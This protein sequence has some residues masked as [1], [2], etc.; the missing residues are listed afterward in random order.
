M[1]KKAVI[2]INY[3]EFNEFLYIKDILKNTSFEFITVLLK[4]HDL[5]FTIPENSYIINTENIF[6]EN[7][8]KE[9]L[10]I[11]KSYNPILIASSSS[12]NIKNIIGKLSVILKCGVLTDCTDI[13]IKG[14]KIIATKYA[15]GGNF[16]AKLLS[17]SDIIAITFKGNKKI[18]DEKNYFKP[19]KEIFVKEDE[20]I[21]LVNKTIIENYSSLENSKKVVGIGRGVK[22]EDIEMIKKF[23]SLI[24]ATVGYTRPVIYEYIGNSEL[25]IGITGK[26]I[27]PDLYIAIGISGKEYHIKGVEKAKKI[28][29]VNTDPQ[30]NIRKY[31]DYFIC[32]DY[33]DFLRKFLI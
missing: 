9:I 15:Y 10:E 32:A 16:V 8:V 12:L 11:I 6:N 19:I 28:I 18:F 2:I 13:Q 22:K 1:V 14:N 4:Y 30:A 3:N 20:N 25:Q 17:K 29:A 21:K 7:I 27:S 23:A 33:K 5:P 26:I 31:A 24:N